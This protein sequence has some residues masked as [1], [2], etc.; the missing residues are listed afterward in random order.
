MRRRLPEILE[1]KGRPIKK[2]VRYLTTC[3]GNTSD[4]DRTFFMFGPP[5]NPIASMYLNFMRL[6][7]DTGRALT[8]WDLH[9][10]ATGTLPSE[11]V[12]KKKHRRD[13]YRIRLRY[14][15]DV[16]M[17]CRYGY[18]RRLAYGRRGHPGR[19][20]RPRNL[21]AVTEKGRESLR[22]FDGM[23]S[24]SPYYE[25]ARRR[26]MSEIKA[27]R[28]GVEPPPPTR[29]V[30]PGMRVFDCHWIWSHMADAKAR[31]IKVDGWRI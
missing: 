3:K 24:V 15:L 2:P 20:G 4:T 8:F 19:K 14:N 11:V 7:E 31:G 22:R 6:I 28:E 18:L 29:T 13:S 9:Q 10:L 16:G 5:A 21:Y 12:V 17:L 1:G 25:D 23:Y 30:E 27:L 26:V